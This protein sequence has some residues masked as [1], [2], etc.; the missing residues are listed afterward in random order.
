MITRTYTAVVLVFWLIAMGWLVSAKILPLLLL[1]DAPDDRKLL[2]SEGEPP[3]VEAWQIRYGD[4]VVGWALSRAER[5]GDGSSQ[6]RSVVRLERLPLDQI[7]SRIIGLL[8]HLAPRD[9][10]QPL[11]DIDMTWKTRVDVDLDNTLTRFATSVQASKLPELIRVEG[12]ARGNKLDLVVRAATQ[13]PR[14]REAEDPVLFEQSYDLPP[15]QLLFDAVAPRTRLEGLQV[16]QTWTSTNYFA[17]TPNAPVQIIQSRVEKQDLLFYEGQPVLTYLV[18]MRDDGGSG[19]STAR[20]PFARLWVVPDSARRGDLRPG[21]VLQQEI[22]M[23]GIRFTFVRQS[24]DA[25]DAHLPSLDTP[26]FP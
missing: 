20:A 10:V 18:E 26:T 7:L 21:D 25:F 13:Q 11:G 17:L 22:S 15:N 6:L 12:T 9:G 19:L 8:R 4:R 3:R 23:L 5:A 24:L 2:P 14:G 16:G 1:G